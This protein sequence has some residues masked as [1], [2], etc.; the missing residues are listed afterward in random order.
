ML[1]R[2]V[3]RRE[4]PVVGD[5]HGPERTASE[6]GLPVAGVIAHEDPRLARRAAGGPVCPP[7]MVGW[8]EGPI[9]VVG[10]VPE[11]TVHRTY[12]NLSPWIRKP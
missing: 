6:I 7:G 11:R 12:V 10:D 8:I 3:S 4:L 9:R 2:C 1:G 5:P